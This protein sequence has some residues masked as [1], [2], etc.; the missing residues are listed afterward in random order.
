MLDP[1][2]VKRYLARRPENHNHVKLATD[3]EL[4]AVLATL[5]IRFREPLRKHQKA[6]IILGID[7]PQFF[8]MLDMGTGKTRITLELLRYW[9]KIGKLRRAVI[10]VPTDLVADSWERQIRRWTPDFP[11]LILTESS[12]KKKWASYDDFPNGLIV[13]T[14]PGLVR[15]LTKRAPHKKK[16]G[17]SKLKP[18]KTLV[19][20][21]A[22]R[23]DA[24]IMDESTKLANKKSLSSRI[25]R[26]LSQTANIR[27]ALAGRA[28]G[29]NP[30]PLWAQFYLVDHGETLG[31]NLGLFRGAFFTETKRKFGGPFA[32]IYTFDE[33]K[34]DTLA[35]M[36]GHRS[37]RYSE[38]EC[39]DLPA[40]IPIVRELSF[41]EDTET[42]YQRM[43]DQI[44]KARGDLSEIKNVFMRMRQIS[45]GFLGFKNEETGERAQVEFDH[46]PKLDD[47][48]DRI[49]NMPSDRKGVVFHE[50]TWSGRRICQE[51]E[52][53]EIGHRWIWGGTK[54]TKRAMDDF[55]E[56]PDVQI[57]VMNSAKGAYGTDGMQEVANYLFFYES[58]VSVID[59]EQAQARLKRD[60]QRHKVFMYDFI[61]QDSMDQRIRDY[62]AAGISLFKALVDDPARVLQRR[63][64]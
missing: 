45:S 60:G 54:D 27:Y 22:D 19:R 57:M 31:A 12:S 28:F 43:V 38:D 5:P 58:P 20:D 37:I 55:L 15:M 29:R 30:T 51:L 42:Y 34:E 56:D 9:N 36:I 11:Y 50:F 10:T 59:R 44:I 21:F 18:K 49:E 52:D 32:K 35:A 1:R 40:L 33:S 8:F 61:M 16:E 41:P 13:V 23:V 64:A 26:K 25:V 53:R 46:N 48:I 24:L 3:K 47:L 62:H 14:Y 6:C 2:A 17:R 7:F 4:D 63:A 39:G